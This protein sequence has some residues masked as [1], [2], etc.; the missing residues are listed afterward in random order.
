MSIELRSEKVRNIIGQI[1]SRTIRTGIMVIFVVLLVLL[2]GAYFFKF[3]YTIDVS[4]QLYTHSNQVR[5]T[6][7]IPQNKIKHI[8]AG[9]KLIITVHNQSSF[10]ATVQNIDSTLHINRQ[11]SY[12]RV[13]GVVENRQLK[14]DEPVKARAKIHISKINVIDYVLLKK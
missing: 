6:L 12:F 11:Q 7:E 4:A 13:Q 9:Q 1:P 14:I 5:Y 3:D 10:T 8:K 2:T